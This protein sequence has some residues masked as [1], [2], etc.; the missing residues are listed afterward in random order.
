M[1]YSEESSDEES[2]ISP[3]PGERYREGVFGIQL[4]KTEQLRIIPSNRQ[5]PTSAIYY[6]YNVVTLRV[7]VRFR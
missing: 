4:T 2:T 7:T 6:E 5:F 1:K 3:P